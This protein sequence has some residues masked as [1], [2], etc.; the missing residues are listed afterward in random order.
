LFSFCPSIRVRRNKPLEDSLLAYLTLVLT[1]YGIFT[2]VALTL[3]FPYNI[4]IV[5]NSAM[6][7]IVEIFVG[8]LID[9]YAK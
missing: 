2:G 8:A 6:I 4:L 1:G 7:G 5:I 3:P 9:M